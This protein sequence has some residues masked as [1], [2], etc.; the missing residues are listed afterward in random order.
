LEYVTLLE[1]TDTNINTMHPLE[2]NMH[3]WNV[4][5]VAITVSILGHWRLLEIT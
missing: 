5:T 1:I 2:E 3:A 4:M